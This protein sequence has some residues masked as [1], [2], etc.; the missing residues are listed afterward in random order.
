M[1]RAAQ[2]MS[3]RSKLRDLRMLLREGMHRL[4]NDRR[5]RVFEKP[6]DEKEVPDYYQVVKRPVC[7]EQI[8]QRVNDHVYVSLLLL[9]A[10]RSD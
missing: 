7:L 9:V 1:E 4:L 6:V 2:Q 3:E 10:H 8:L 5:F